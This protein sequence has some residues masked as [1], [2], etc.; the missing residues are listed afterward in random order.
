MGNAFPAPPVEIGRIVFR[1]WEHEW[2]TGE[3][4][5]RSIASAK[6]LLPIDIT[7][8]IYAILER[9]ER[10]LIRSSLPYSPYRLRVR[11]ADA[12]Q[13]LVLS[14]YPDGFVACTE[15]GR[16]G[17]ALREL[18]PSWDAILPEPRYKKGKFGN[19]M[20]APEADHPL[21]WAYELEWRSEVFPTGD[22]NVDALF[23]RYSPRRST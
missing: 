9:W 6:R 18:C 16:R 2:Q 5:A 12:W 21:D 8:P 7:Q 15:I 17:S 3:R 22:V 10:D 20:Q 23:G 4:E 11:R 13:S 19:A 1:S 14:S